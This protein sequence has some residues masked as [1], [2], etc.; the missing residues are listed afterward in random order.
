MRR[1]KSCLSATGHFPFLFVRSGEDI[2][3]KV[4]G[5]QVWDGTCVSV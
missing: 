1:W 4:K 5:T 3:R 2:R